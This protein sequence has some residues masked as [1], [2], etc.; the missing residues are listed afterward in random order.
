MVQSGGSQEVA[1]VLH[2][3]LESVWWGI[4]G[5]LQPL[6]KRSGGPAKDCSVGVLREGQREV[7]TQWP[8]LSLRM[9]LKSLIA[10]CF[11]TVLEG[12]LGG[13]ATHMQQSTV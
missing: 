13:L 5:T 12:G 3:V 8:L 4:F 6:R 2:G 1:Q 7:F 11:I 10:H 9:G